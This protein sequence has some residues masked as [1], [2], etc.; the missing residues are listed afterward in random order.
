[1]AVFKDGWMGWVRGLERVMFV[2]GDGCLGALDGFEG[3][4]M[5]EFMVLRMNGSMDGWMNG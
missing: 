3:G 5:D 1:V 2:V 4:W